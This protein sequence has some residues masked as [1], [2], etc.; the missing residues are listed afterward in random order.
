MQDEI[1]PVIDEMMLVK[2][3]VDSYLKSSSEGFHLGD[4][5]RNHSLKRGEAFALMD[6]H[7]V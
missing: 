1:K 6:D 2:F 4:K 7:E 5:S 3:V